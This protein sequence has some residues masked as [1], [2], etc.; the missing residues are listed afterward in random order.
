MDR[1]TG[2]RFGRSAHLEDSRRQ[3][4]RLRQRVE[5][6]GL[7][8]SQTRQRCGRYAVP[9]LALTLFQV[10]IRV[11]MACE[12]LESTDQ[13]RIL[14]DAWLHRRLAGG[15][16]LDRHRGGNRAEASEHLVASVW[17]P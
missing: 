12:W 5:L 8:D 16:R 13:L 10:S 6:D 7:F 11:E 15:R 17:F 9:L 14:L 1:P 2:N 4:A 3:L